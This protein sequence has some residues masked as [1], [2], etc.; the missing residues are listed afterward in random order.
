M[1]TFKETLEDLRKLHIKPDERRAIDLLLKD[2]SGTLYKAIA[3]L[4]QEEEAKV[5]AYEK[6]LSDGQRLGKRGGL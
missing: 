5:R 4:N 3:I 1:K 6:L 2:G